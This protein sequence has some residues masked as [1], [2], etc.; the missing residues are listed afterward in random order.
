LQRQ[1]WGDDLNTATLTAPAVKET[2]PAYRWYCLAVLTLIYSC[3]FLD[4]AIVQLVVEPVRVEFQLTDSQL[5][6]LTG[7]LFGIVFALSSIPMGMLVDRVNRRNMLAGVVLLWSGATA[8]CGF[9]QSFWTLLVARMGVGAAEAGGSPTSMSMIGDIFPPERRATAVG[10]FYMNTV[11]GALA[12]ALIGRHVAEAY[13]WRAAFLVAGLPGILLAILLLLTV[14]EP[15]RGGTD[16]APAAPVPV[17]EALKTIATQP[18]LVALLIAVPLA[19]MGV[20]AMGAWLSPFLMRVH[21][22]SLS[23]AGD[24][25]ALAS[26]PFAAAGALLG[27]ALSDRLGK[28]NPARRFDLCAVAML[29]SMPLVFGT[30]MATGTTLSVVC[31]VFAFGIIFAVI[32]VGF[33]SMLVLTS[34]GMRGISAS[35]LQLVSNLVGYGVGPYAVGWLSDWHGGPDSLRF[36]ILTVILVSA[37][38]SAIM[39]WV[40]RRHVARTMN[41][42]AAL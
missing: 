41:V 35:A 14:K 9:A 6:L 36:A 25:L 18:T 22:M 5:G 37:S 30:T 38:A 21:H 20:S 16:A 12:V 10:I 4:R 19:T 39:F 2:R 34:A 31:T 26:G 11:L 32:P 42:P 40:A 17:G 15:R 29:L 27:G 28:S 33:G 24:V 8:V 23:E 13:G 3:H 7:L 1:P